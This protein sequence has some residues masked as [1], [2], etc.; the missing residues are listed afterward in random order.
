[1]IADCGLLALDD[2]SLKEER[3]GGGEDPY[4]DFPMDED[5]DTENP[6]VALEIARVVRDVGNKLFKE[7]KTEDALYKYESEFLLVP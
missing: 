4:E 7:G 3:V 5:R 1:M 6:Q 2:P